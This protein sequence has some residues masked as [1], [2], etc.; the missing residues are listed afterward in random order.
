[1]NYSFTNKNVSIGGKNV[2]TDWRQAKVVSPDNL[3]E[4]IEANEEAK[5]EVKRQKEVTPKSNTT[6]TAEVA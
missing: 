3:H 5:K 2:I 1:M 4:K 6:A